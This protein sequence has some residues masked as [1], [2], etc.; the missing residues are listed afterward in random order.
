M[1]EQIQPDKMYILHSKVAVEVSDIE[2][3]LF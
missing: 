2:Q 3:H 1:Y